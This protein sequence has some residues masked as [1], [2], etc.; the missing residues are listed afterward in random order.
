LFCSSSLAFQPED[1][2]IVGPDFDI[3]I[4]NES[5]CPH[6]GFTIVAANERFKLDP[7]A[8]FRNPAEA[9][10]WHVIAWSAQVGAAA[11]SGGMRRSPVG[12][13]FTTASSVGLCQ[14]N[15]ALRCRKTRLT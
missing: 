2:A 13:R 4:L 1:K 10:R 5:L 14:T 11:P 6:H 15:G 8:V 12:G 3:V 9:I 7:P